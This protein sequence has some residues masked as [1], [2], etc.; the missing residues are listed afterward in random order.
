MWPSQAEYKSAASIKFTLIMQLFLEGL[1]FMF[2]FIS[3]RFYPE[4]PLTSKN[5]TRSQCLR[6]LVG[7]EWKLGF[8]D[9]LSCKIYVSHI[10]YYSGVFCSFVLHWLIF[11]II[12]FGL[13]FQWLRESCP[14]SWKWLQIWHQWS[15]L[16]PTLSSP[17][18]LSSPIV[19]SSPQTNASVTRL[20][21]Y[22]DVEP[23]LFKF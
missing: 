11:L 5:S 10:K 6:N 3:I 20:V 22:E 4:E 19:K 1:P 2:R 9:T 21:W 16:L 8:V 14:S 7:E 18:R 17:V 23:E 13:F 12:T 15:R